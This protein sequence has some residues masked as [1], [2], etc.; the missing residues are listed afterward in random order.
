MTTY[1]AY[2]ADLPC[3]NQ[4]CKSHGSPH[5]N[6]ECYPGLMAEGGEIKDFCS[7]NQPHQESCQYFADGGAAFDPD[8]YLKEKE[9]GEEF[10][11]DAYLQDK[12][13]EKHSGIGS[14]IGAGVEGFLQGSL[15]PAGP[16][17][18]T[19]LLKP[20]KTVDPY[21]MA[22]AGVTEFDKGSVPVITNEDIEGRATA[23][24]IAHTVGEIAGMVSPV[25]LVGGIA[26][27]TGFLANAIQ[28]GLFQASDEITKAMLGE[29][30]PNEAVASKLVHSGEN[31]LL[32][33]GASAIAG[34]AGRG[35]S[36]GAGKVGDAALAKIE[37]KIGSNLHSWLTGLGEAASGIAQK[38]EDAGYNKG[39][40][41][42]NKISN[43]YVKYGTELGA[44]G[45]DL[46]IRMKR[47]DDFG[48]ALWGVSKDFAGAKLAKY[49]LP[50]I[51]K[52]LLKAIGS[53]ETNPGA[54]NKISEYTNDVMKGDKKISDSVE[55]LFGAGGQQIFN[56]NADKSKEKLHKWLEENGPSQDINQMIEESGAM[57]GFA[58]GGQVEPKQSPML[59]DEPIA[60][61]FPDQHLLLSSAKGR[62]SGYLN[63]LRPK[64]N[65]P[66]LVFDV[67]PDQ[68]QQKKTY[69]RALDTVVNPLGIMGKIKKGTVDP[70][71]LQHFNSLHPELSEVLKKRITKKIVDQQL[72]GEKPSYKIRQGLS[73]FLGAPLSGEM[74]P[75]NIMAAQATFKSKQPP[76]PPPQKKTSAISKSSQHLMTS[77]QAAASR[78]QKQ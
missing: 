36:K 52:V 50:N 68:T 8:A 31:I 61:N 47:G 21:S 11:P 5:P 73:M 78:Q 55:H 26:K 23:H 69:N 74:L 20:S 71:D 24:P 65:Q 22:K 33:A 53:G 41:F 9:G 18:E 43:S 67:E 29:G 75:Q 12:A 16:L 2:N 63:N 27:G 28:G 15:G 51:G 14:T 37:N 46:G 25:S 32:A 19:E 44:A 35:F 57:P 10:N 4:S 56:D 58:H 13:E 64:G 66:K 30:D 59:A 40:Q 54:L 7:S 70:E 49:F 6:C 39:V 76:S 38:S 3:K 48:D 45:I 72:K 1:G 62:M 42:Y 60:R 17:A 77:D 34:E